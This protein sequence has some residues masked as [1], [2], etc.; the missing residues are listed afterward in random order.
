MKTRPAGNYF[1]TLFFYVLNVVLVLI[2]APEVTAFE[3]IV[4]AY[5]MLRLMAYDPIVKED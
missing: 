1:Q 3:T 4:C 5:I 2:V